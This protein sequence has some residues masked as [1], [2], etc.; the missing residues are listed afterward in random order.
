MPAVQVPITI[1]TRLP[2]VDSCQAPPRIQRPHRILATS[3][4]RSLAITNPRG[5]VHVGHP[6]QPNVMG[7]LQAHSMAEPDSLI[8]V[9]TPASSCSPGYHYQPVPKLHTLI[10]PY[11]LLSLALSTSWW[12]LFPQLR[13]LLCKKQ[14]WWLV[15]GLGLW[16]RPLVFLACPLGV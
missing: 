9:R 12:A 11:P 6:A 15:Q 1:G 14:L 5:H 10:A 8:L 4:T 2:K 7:N 3:L 13:L 16:G